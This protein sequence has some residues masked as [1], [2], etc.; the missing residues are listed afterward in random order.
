MLFII[1][2]FL[3][4]FPWT[5][6][7]YSNPVSI[8]MELMSDCGR[9]IRARKSRAAVHT[10]NIYGSVHVKVSWV[11]VRVGTL[12]AKRQGRLR[13]DAFPC[14][15]GTG[16]QV[17]NEYTLWSGADKIEHP[18]QR[19]PAIWLSKPPPLTWC[20]SAIKEPQFVAVTDSDSLSAQLSY[21]FTQCDVWDGFK[22]PL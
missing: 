14:K 7:K 20:I 2:I 21:N 17:C 9:F 12:T 3:L 4:L 10:V 13:Q 16:S 5:L 19:T 8:W 11:F 22:F 18:R 15:D 6:H 1:C